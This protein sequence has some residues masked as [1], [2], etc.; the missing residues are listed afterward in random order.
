MAA[1]KEP[2]PDPAPDRRLDA[3]E[4][5]GEP[6]GDI[7]AALEQLNPEESLLLINSFEPEPLYSVLE[8][9]GFTYESARI[10]DDEWHVRIQ[11]A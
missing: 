6:F 9:R 3:R 5:D 11:P 4:I 10:E 1:E 7:M 2:D 8:Q